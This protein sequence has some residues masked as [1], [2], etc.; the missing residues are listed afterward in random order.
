[1]IVDT[2][3]NASPRLDV[4]GD[5]FENWMIVDTKLNANPRLDVPGDVECT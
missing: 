5:V 1:M 2:K 3:M 4:P